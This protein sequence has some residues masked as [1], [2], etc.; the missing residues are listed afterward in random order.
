MDGKCLEEIRVRMR[1]I[2]TICSITN[3]GVGTDKPFLDH[4]VSS[5]SS[6][7]TTSNFADVPGTVG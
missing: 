5:S 1:M 3:A 4:T 6:S 7:T 2:L